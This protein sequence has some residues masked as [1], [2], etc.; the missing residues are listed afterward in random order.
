MVNIIDLG[1]YSPAHVATHRNNTKAAE[2]LLAH[3]CDVDFMR[4]GTGA[5]I[6][7]AV[8][9]G[10]KKMVQM[11]LEPITKQL[12]QAR[13]D[14]NARTSVSRCTAPSSAPE[15]GLPSKGPS[16]FGKERFMEFFGSKSSQPHTQLHTQL[17]GSKSSQPHTQ[18]HTQLF[19][20]KRSQPHTQ[21]H[22]QLFG[23]KSSQPHTQLHTQLFG[24]K[25]SQPSSL[26]TKSFD[27]G[28][29]L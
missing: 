25:S 1:G 2:V 27:R 26:R 4:N 16:T 29:A 20:S 11:L 5:A 7:I 6:H 17:F 24:S 28:A 19:G 9:R 14:A 8:E 3:G 21:L 23:S 15:P 10:H 22:T 13:D 12:L 18:L